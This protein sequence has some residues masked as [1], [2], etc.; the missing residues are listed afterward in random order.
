ML[1]CRIIKIFSVLLVNHVIMRYS[2]PGSFRLFVHVWVIMMTTL[3]EAP[4][5]QYLFLFTNNYLF[6]AIVHYNTTNKNKYSLDLSLQRSLTSATTIIYQ[7]YL[8]QSLFCRSSVTFSLYPRIHLTNTV[9]I[10][11]T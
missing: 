6:L 1:R 7:Y 10:D 3:H 4:E 5:A 2:H 9:P 8:R 11:T